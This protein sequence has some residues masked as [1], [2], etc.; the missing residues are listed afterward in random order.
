VSVAAI[1]LTYPQPQVALLTFDL[2]GKS[3]NV[4]SAGVMAELA[5]HL[6]TLRNTADLQ[7]VILT[8]GKPGTFIAGADIREVLSWHTPEEEQN[9]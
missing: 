5:A 8:S 9:V 2:P 1:S 4:L 6:Q 7:A 3:A